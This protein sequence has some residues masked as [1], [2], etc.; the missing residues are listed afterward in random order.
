M[1]AYFSIARMHTL[2]KLITMT[3]APQSLQC[4]VC[5]HNPTI[6]HASARNGPACMGLPVETILPCMYT[7]Y[8][9]KMKG[10]KLMVRPAVRGR[11]G[12]PQE[13]VCAHLLPKQHN[14]VSTAHAILTNNYRQFD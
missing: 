8:T 5:H 14:Y 2:M 12:I 13:F 9:H 3:Q 1:H 11:Q 10:I 6:S 7:A 4:T